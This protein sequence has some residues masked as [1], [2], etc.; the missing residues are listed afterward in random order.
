MTPESFQDA[1]PKTM[2]MMPYSLFQQ[3]ALQLANCDRHLVFLHEPHGA[4]AEQYR[5]LASRLVH[6][7]PKGGTLMVTSPAPEDGKTLT[8]INLAFCLAERA[9]TLLVDLDTR[10]SSIREYL[11]LALNGPGIEDALLELSRPEDCVYS[12]HNSHLCVAINCGESHATF[13]LMAAGRPQRFLAWAQKRF[14]WVIFDTPPA[15][16]IADTLDIAQHTTV[17]ILVVRSRKTPIR[18]AQQTIEALKGRLHHVVL[19]DGEKPSYS[20]YNRTYYFK[21][22]ADS[23]RFK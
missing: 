18:L 8:A 7:H 5:R 13:E 12:L 2:A 16:P 10:R 9:P 15:F 11:G 1:Q 21:Q 22:V 4:A 3:T 6:A 23:G 20:L 19:N 14:T 17:G